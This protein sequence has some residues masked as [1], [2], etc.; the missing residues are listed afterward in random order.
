MNFFKLIFKKI[1]GCFNIQ[2][3]GI[4]KFGLDPTFY[5]IHLGHFFIIN[6]L[7]FLVKKNFNIVI[8]IG[9]YTTFLKKKINKN[10]IILNSICLKSQ[11][12]NI[13]GEIDIFFNSIWVINNKLSFFFKIF[14][15]INTN[16][17]ICQSIKNENQEK[18]NIK[19]LLYPLIQAYDSLIINSYIEIGGIDQLLNIICARF[20]QKIFKKLKQNSI[21]FILLENK[22]KKLS[23]SDNNDLTLSELPKIL[24][25]LIFYNIKTYIEKLFITNCYKFIFLKIKKNSFYFKKR[26]FLSYYYKKIFK[27]NK[28]CFNNK[29]YK[30][31]LFLN[32]KLLINNF[33][34]KKIN[35]NFLNNKIKIYD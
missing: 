14:D 34:L 5:S 11:I 19:K 25:N 22:N 26:N 18:L 35:Y 27:N 10:I 21:L 24:I 2:K 20:M 17:Y 13:I 31:K 29:I 28:F 23:K 4:I 3:I 15:L 6:F 9:D 30:K 1:I 8:I 33:F 16:K 32:D 7:F 12:Y